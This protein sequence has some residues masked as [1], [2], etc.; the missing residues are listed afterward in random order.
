MYKD[1]LKVK[2]ILLYTMFEHKSNNEFGGEMPSDDDWNHIVGMVKWL[3]CP[4]RMSTYLGGSKYPTLSVVV[5]A[6]TR[7][8]SHCNQY[9][10][11]DIKSI[12]SYS[13]RITTQVQQDAS[14]KCLGYLIKCQES[15][16]LI[17]SRIAKF[18]DPRYVKIF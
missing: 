2:N 5:L 6:F 7:L 11:I 15:C 14:E 4:S 18:L 1:V 13:L 12:E 8:L 16:K 3:E 10:G 9:V 17:P